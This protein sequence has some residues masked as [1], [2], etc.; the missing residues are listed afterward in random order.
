MTTPETE[1]SY[2]QVWK[3]KRTGREA[4]IKEVVAKDWLLFQYFDTSRHCTWRVEDFK[5]R[6]AFSHVHP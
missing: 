5:K 4:F 6:F 3:H 1:P 2:G